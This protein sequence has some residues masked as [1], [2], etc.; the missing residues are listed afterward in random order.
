M[1]NEETVCVVV[2]DANV[3]IN[4]IHIEQLDLLCALP[5]LKFV[6]P[7]H[8]VD[9]ITDPDQKKVLE[10]AL[11]NN[12]LERIMITELAEME[13]YVELHR[14][15]GQGEAACLAIAKY[16]G[17]RVASD[18]KRVFR[19]LVLERIGHNRLLT[20]SDLILHAV[21][22]RLT[23]VVEADQWKERLQEHRFMVKFESFA[24]LL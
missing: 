2:T 12:H 20:T 9:E 14:I 11:N 24:D 15:L 21:R 1:T 22:S 3:I 17:Y 7:E 6:V 8:V 16:R 5:G 4:F 19:R 13:N 18:E 23:T 10:T